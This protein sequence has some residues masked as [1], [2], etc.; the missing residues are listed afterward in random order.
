MLTD[1]V[2]ADGEALE[3]GSLQTLNDASADRWLRR[4]KAELI[5]D[6]PAPKVK[7]PTEDELQ[8]L[9]ESAVA[10]QQAEVAAAVA[11]EE[12]KPKGKSK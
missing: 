3:A 1:E 8:T 5:K 4:G 12:K 7:T 9:V 2:G 6:A 10:D 11:P